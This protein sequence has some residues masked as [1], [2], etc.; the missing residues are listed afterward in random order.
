MRKEKDMMETKCKCG[1]IFVETS[2]HDDMDWVLHCRKCRKE[3]PR[4]K[5]HGKEKPE[6]FKDHGEGI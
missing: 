5:K 2:I 1:G 4:Y 6:P 3:I